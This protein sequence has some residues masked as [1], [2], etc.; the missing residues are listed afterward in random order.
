MSWVGLC[1]DLGVVISLWID[2]LDYW[3]GQTL[4]EWDAIVVQGCISWIFGRRT[5]ET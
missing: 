4:L 3:L 2:V 5:Q 1:Y